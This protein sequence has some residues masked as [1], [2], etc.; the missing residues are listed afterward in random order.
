VDKQ[1]WS[2]T[3]LQTYNERKYAE[4]LNKSDISGDEVAIKNPFFDAES[5][6]CADNPTHHYYYPFT[7]NKV[8][9]LIENPE[10][11]DILEKLP[12]KILDTQKTQFRGKAYLKVISC[13]PVEVK[14][15]RTMSYKQMI[16]AWMPFDHLTPDELKVW[17]IIVDTAYADRINI[18]AISYPGWL[19]DSPLQILAELRGDV[20][21]VNKPTYAK[22][23]L[24]VS[25]GLKILGLNEIQNLK[26]EA[27]D[28]LAKYYEDTGDFKN[29]F[30][31]DSRSTSGTT[32]ESDISNHSNMTFYNFPKKDGQLLFDDLFDDKVIGRI[33]PLLLSGGT[34]TQTA[35]QEKFP[36]VDKHISDDEFAYLNNFL[37]NHKYYEMNAREELEFKPW[38][39]KY[40]HKFNNVRYRRNYETVLLRLKL[41]AET[42]TEYHELEDIF[43]SM[44]TNY[45]DY[46]K[47]YRQ[48]DYI[49]LGKQQDLSAIEE[50]II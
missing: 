20:R 36:H 42:E 5:E 45:L 25:N 48:G 11:A 47:Q 50:E 8:N 37:K 38:K 13:R 46:I 28:P 10:G 3:K 23:K 1:I 41:Y 4:I 7:K 22:I 29:K 35:V 19:K 17:K 27:K 30:V 26:T 9:Y 24:F 39:S 12:V 21:A 14:A 32:E 40:L 33:F 18:R 15:E 34:Q 43:Y 2:Y 6:M 16:D 49:W 31:A 44:H